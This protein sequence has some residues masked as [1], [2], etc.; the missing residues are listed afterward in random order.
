MNVISIFSFAALL[1]NT[2]IIHVIQSHWDYEKKKT[3]ERGRERE[4]K[5]KNQWQNPTITTTTTIKKEKKWAQ[6]I[7]A[8]NKARKSYT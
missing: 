6:R 1:L 3:W 5:I 2:I 8:K 7:I 4:K